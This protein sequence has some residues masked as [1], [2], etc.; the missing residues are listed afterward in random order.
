MAM[1]IN[2]FSAPGGRMNTSMPPNLLEVMCVKKSLSHVILS[3]QGADVCSF[4]IPV[5]T[6]CGGWRGTTVTVFEAPSNSR[7]RSLHQN[8]PPLPAPQR[9]LLR[10]PTPVPR[11]NQPSAIPQHSNKIPD[12]PPSSAGP[13]KALPRVIQE[14]RTTPGETQ[15][16]SN[17]WTSPAWVPVAMS[18]TPRSHHTP[19]IHPPPI[20]SLF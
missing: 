8:L 18:T 11:V 19:S 2:Q 14:G 1:T 20:Y 13:A 15:I 17:T 10:C 3:L 9:P 7:G 6:S 16:Q 12:K 4:T 5:V